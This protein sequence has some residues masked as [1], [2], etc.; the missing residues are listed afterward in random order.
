MCR[1]RN[2]SDEKGETKTRKEIKRL[3]GGR[4]SCIERKVGK[5]EE[6]V[7]LRKEG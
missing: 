7:V 5:T 4:E 3:R 6:K 1:K 2:M